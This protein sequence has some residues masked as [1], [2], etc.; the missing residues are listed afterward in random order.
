MD[1]PGDSVERACTAQRREYLLHGGFRTEA[2]GRG[3]FPYEFGV[4]HGGLLSAVRELPLVVTD[5]WTRRSVLS[6]TVTAGVTALAG[7]AAA[8]QAATT[9]RVV[10]LSSEEFT[11]GDGYAGYFI[12]IGSESTSE[13]SVSDLED[14]QFENYNPSS[15]AAYDGSLID[16]QDEA[17]RQLPI[18]IYT[19]AAADI[20]PGTLWVVNR[21]VDCPSGD[22]VGLELEQIGA[23][24]VRADPEG[25][26]GGVG[27]PG[28]GPL[29]A[30]AGLIGGGWALSRRE[31]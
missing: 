6:A 4:P 26:S 29:A 30:I 7:G 13:F 19:A 24:V 12:H 8:R 27:L 31:Q 18:Q 17:S 1:P 21:G 25:A 5:R 16:R 2:T 14:C 10:I 9:T 15:V 3:S 23:T 22:F 20:D 11:R 28:F